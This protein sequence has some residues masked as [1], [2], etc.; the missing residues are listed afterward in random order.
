MKQINTVLL[1]DDDFATNYLHKM[2]IEEHGAFKNIAEAY[3][4]QEAIDYLTT[5]VDGVYPRPDMIF[6][7][8]NMPRMDGWEFLD[9]YAGLPEECKG[10]AV[11]AMLTTSLNP[12]DRERSQKYDCVKCF[13]NKP[14]D[15]EKLDRLIETL[16]PGG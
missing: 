11:I 16:N 9:A 2:V 15:L 6:L 5:E 4:G 14:L 1:V 13:E 12:D 10:G 8:I 3:D 7:D